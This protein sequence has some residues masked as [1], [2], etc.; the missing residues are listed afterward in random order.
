M[1]RFGMT[2]PFDGVALPAQEGAI[3]EME[4]LAGLHTGPALLAQSAASMA[5]AAPGRFVLG[6]GT[7]SDVIVENWNGIAFA[8][9]YARVRDTVRFLRAALAGEK[10]TEEHETFSIRG[11][12]LG[13]EVAEPVPIVIAAL[14]EGTLRL[15]GRIGDGA[16]INWLAPDDVTRVAAIVRGERICSASIGSSGRRAGP[17]GRARQDSRV[18]R[19]PVVGARHAG[20]ASRPTPEPGRRL[21]R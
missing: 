13:V 6:L 19:R 4:A 17:Q 2:I 1:K 5:A 8:D 16:I 12:R 14:R 15:A 11:F 18:G 10:V 20:R 21:S 3:R 7:S 9:P